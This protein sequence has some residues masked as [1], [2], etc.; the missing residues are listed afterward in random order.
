MELPNTLVLA[1]DSS[2]LSHQDFLILPELAL[3]RWRG[4]T[5]FREEMRGN[6]VEHEIVLGTL[7]AWGKQECSS[8]HPSPTPPTLSAWQELW[9]S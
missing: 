8:D 3:A 2:C 5:G 9:A 7:N 6:S 1:Y 4:G